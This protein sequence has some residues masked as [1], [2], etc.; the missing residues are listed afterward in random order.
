M[1]SRMLILVGF[2]Y[3]KAERRP[4]DSPKI[5]LKFLSYINLICFNKNNHLYIFAFAW[6]IFTRQREYWLATCTPIKQERH[7]GYKIGDANTRFLHSFSTFVLILF[8]SPL[9]LS[10]SLSIFNGCYSINSAF[11]STQFSG[12][13]VLWLSTVNWK[14]LSATLSSLK[15]LALTT[16]NWRLSNTDIFI[17]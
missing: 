17:F 6:T 4:N 10:R 3:L 15:R 13:L 14:L 5:I 12:S 16:R 8:L 2:M 1:N 11:L 7:V 9:S